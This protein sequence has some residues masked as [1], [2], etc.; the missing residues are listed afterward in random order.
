MYPLKTVLINFSEH[1]IAS[2]REALEDAQ[3]SIEAV[4]ADVNR[5]VE[6]WTWND[7]DSRLALFYIESMQDVKDLECLKRAFNWP[8][9]AVVDAPRDQIATL[10]ILANR[11]GAA[12]VVALPLDPDDLRAGLDA[13]CREH[14]YHGTEGRS[15]AVTGVTGGCGATTVAINLADCVAFHHQRHCALVELAMQKGMLA[16]YLNVDPK[17]VLPD[18]L[19]PGIKLDQHVVRQALTRIA[20]NFDIVSGAH[21]QITPVQVTTPDL[22]RLIEH[23]RRAADV[24]VLDVPWT[25]DDQFVQSLSAASHVVLVAEQN[26]PSLRSLKLVLD[27]LGRSDLAR[28]AGGVLVEAVVNR[29]DPRSRDFPLERVREVLGVPNLVTVANDYPSVNASVNR[30]EPLRL[31]APKSRALADIVALTNKLFG[32]PE[33]PPAPASGRWN[34]LGRLA[35]VFSGSST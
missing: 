9:L 6:K 27:M 3:V 8:V 31:G 26:L 29:Y 24:L 2:F 5:A 28:K 13:I 12:Q 11:A 15:V 19:Q 4:F 20:D 22:L 10:L 21:M 17:Y 33:A 1:G 35:R 16:T 23:F 25:G 18:L 14:G 7:S 30:G 32:A 34:L